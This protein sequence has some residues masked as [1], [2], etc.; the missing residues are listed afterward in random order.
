M[1][2]FTSE[3]NCTVPGKTGTQF[4]CLPALSALAWKSGSSSQEGLW[5]DLS[6][7]SVVP[8]LGPEGPFHGYSCLVCFIYGQLQYAVFWAVFEM[9]QFQL[10][11]NVGSTGI[12]RYAYVTPCL[13]TAAVT[14]R[15][16]GTVQGTGYRLQIPDIRCDCHHSPI[17]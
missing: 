11:Q 7:V 14:G 1:S 2:W 13:W 16:P 8:L 3:W 12:P 5:T 9:H 17:F 4:G 10:I 6:C 15:F